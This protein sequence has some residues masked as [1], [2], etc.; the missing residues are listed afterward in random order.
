M[1]RSARTG[2]SKCIR[3]S[4]ANTV[5]RAAVDLLETLRIPL[6]KRALLV[7]F[8]HQNRER[9]PSQASIAINAHNL[10]SRPHR[11]G[12]QTHDFA[13]TAPYVK[14]PHSRAEASAIEH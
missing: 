12:H 14:T 8:I 9:F 11:L 6:D 3:K 5:K 4:R 10:I 7:A 1:S 2:S 13:R